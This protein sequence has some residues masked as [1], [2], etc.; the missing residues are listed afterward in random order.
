MKRRYRPRFAA[1]D[2]AALLEVFLLKAGHTQVARKSLQAQES[3]GGSGVIDRWVKPLTAPFHA[4][5]R[6]AQSLGIGDLD[7]GQAQPFR[8]KTPADE[9]T[10]CGHECRFAGADHAHTVAQLI[11]RRDPGAHEL[12]QP[13]ELRG[14][15]D[16]LV[17]P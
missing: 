5:V 1:P 9:H 14:I 2:L 8:S 17:G 4:W 11:H 12:G 16:F 7:A 10:R 3:S 6:V 13:L 15:H